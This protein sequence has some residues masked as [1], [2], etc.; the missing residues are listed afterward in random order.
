MDRVAL[1]EHKRWVVKVGSALLTDDGR[2]LNAGFI[3]NLAAQI[4]E[5]RQKHIEVVLVSS[6]SVA[7]GLSQLGLSERPDLINQLQAAASVGQASLVRQYEDVFRPFEINIAQ[8]LLT[9]ADIANRE[10]YLN[11]RSTLLTLLGYGALPIINENDAV[12]T[13]EI[14]FGD[15]DSLGALVA[16]LVD[17]EL[18]VILTDQNGLYTA[19]PRSNPGAELLSTAQANDASLT[20]MASGGSSVGRG[21]MVTKLSAAQ[22][23][24]RSGAHTIIA[25][26]REPRILPRL[27]QGEELGTL[28][29]AKARV[30]LKKQWVAGQMKV[31]GTFVLDEGAVKMLQSA[32]KSLLPVGVLEVRGEFTRG[33]FV[34]CVSVDGV[35]VARGLSNYSALEANKVKGKSSDMILELLGYGR[36]SELIHR[37]NLVLV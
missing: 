9:H 3:A 14:C 33:A 31:A 15:N 25:S 12:A 5:L 22:I 11:A 36:E 17:A 10:R 19:D 30:A 29:T 21:G 6:G 27:F 23:A 4:A 20:G 8:V 16:N 35:E 24:S 26:G 34:Q 18:L 28:L 37:D 7:A 1:K 32:G 13:D 2:G